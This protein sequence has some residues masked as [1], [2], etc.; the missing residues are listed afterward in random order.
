M[1]DGW[2]AAGAIELPR[3]PVLAV[4]SVK[5]INTSGVETTLAPSAYALDK[6]SEPG[7]LLPAYDTDW[8]EARDT[9]NAVRVRYTAGFGTAATDVPQPLRA[10]GS[11]CTPRRRTTTAPPWSITAT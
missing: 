7:W 11:R 8:P 10:C 2:P 4:T 3:A 9:A 6:D 1:L 5:Y